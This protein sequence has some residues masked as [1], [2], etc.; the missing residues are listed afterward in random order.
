MVRKTTGVACGFVLLCGTLAGCGAGQREA[1]ASETA[2]D[3]LAAL[4]RGDTAAACASLSPEAAEALAASEGR[5]CEASL[6]LQDLP[7][8]AVEAV[9]VWGDRA[10]VRTDMDVLFLAELDSGWK[11]VAAGCRPQGERPYQCEVDGS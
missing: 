5:S 7:G 9:D 2:E 3:F 1:A 10:Q 6:S 8:G 4:D 11:I